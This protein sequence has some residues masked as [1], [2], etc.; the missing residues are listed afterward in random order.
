MLYVLFCRNMQALS[1]LVHKLKDNQY[2]SVLSKAKM[3]KICTVSQFSCFNTLY[4]FLVR[5][6]LDYFHYLPNYL[7]TLQSVVLG[8]IEW[9]TAE[10]KGYLKLH[11]QTRLISM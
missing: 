7:G 8:L 4:C 1:D 11:L 2:T 6:L 10:N 9:T 3:S 5:Q